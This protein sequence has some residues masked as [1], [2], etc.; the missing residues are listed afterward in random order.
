MNVFI[1]GNGVSRKNFDIGSLKGKGILIGCNW[2]YTEYPFDVI[3]S[4]DPEVSAKIEKEWKGDWIRRDDYGNRRN[5]RDYMYWN[6]H[7]KLIC[8][9]PQLAGATGWNT[10]RAIIYASRKKF[11]PEKIYLFGFDLDR[12]NLYEAA[13]MVHRWQ[14]MPEG[15]IAGWNSLFHKVKERG[16][17]DVIRVGPKDEA[18]KRLTCK[19]ITY[20]EFSNEVTDGL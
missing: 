8:V 3:C 10:G 2:A 15:F 14:T 13:N 12:T 5:N 19:H 4:A 1:F 16:G 11:N 17:A 9:L 6:T 18:S 7:E 20:E